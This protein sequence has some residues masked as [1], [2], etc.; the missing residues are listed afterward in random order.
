MSDLQIIVI[1][2]SMGGL[3]GLMF[4]LLLSSYLVWKH[5]KDVDRN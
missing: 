2:S 3:I 4:S 5:N 1:S